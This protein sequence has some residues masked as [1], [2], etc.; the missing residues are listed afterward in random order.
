MTVVLQGTVSIRPVASSDAGALAD[1]YA[2]NRAYLQPWEP[3][4]PDGFYTADGQ[5]E[6][7]AGCLAEQAAGR[8]FFWALFDGAH[9]AGCI[10]LTD[11]VHGAFE[12]GHLG[13][14]VARDCQGT[15]LA[16][17]AA[18]FVCTFAA[19]LGLHRLQSATLVHNAGSRKVLARS[20]FTEIG[21][22][23]NYIQINGSWQD[24]V[25]FQKILH[26]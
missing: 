15:G 6:R 19:D 3:V 8:S 12:N 2:H 23:G 26:D 18:Q 9:V 11:V 25:L 16:T 20:G 10:S 17:A 24:H 5:R 13:Y 22:A 7:L 21:T 1:A 14:W 4:R